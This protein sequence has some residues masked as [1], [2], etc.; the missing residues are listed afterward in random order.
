MSDSDIVLR[1]LVRD[2][3]IKAGGKS[4]GTTRGNVSA[5]FPFCAGPMK[6]FRLKSSSLS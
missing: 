1:P 2:F 5:K 4:G 6:S 3:P